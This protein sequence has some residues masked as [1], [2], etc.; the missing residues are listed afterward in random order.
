[1]D[2]QKYSLNVRWKDGKMVFGVAH[3]RNRFFMCVSGFGNI[4][5]FSENY[6]Q[7]FKQSSCAPRKKIA[8]LRKTELSEKSL[9]CIY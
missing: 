3:F 6:Y 4:G 2:G 1:M 8:T 9:Y 5:N 7:H